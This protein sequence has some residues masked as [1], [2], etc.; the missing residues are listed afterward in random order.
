MVLVHIWV[1]LWN[2]IRREIMEF[3]WKKMSFCTFLFD[4]IESN[5]QGIYDANYKIY[6]LPDL[7]Q[8]VLK[9]PT[10]RGTTEVPRLWHEAV[11]RNVVGGRRRRNVSWNRSKVYGDG[12]VQARWLIRLLNYELEL[13]WL[14]RW[15]W[16]RSADVRVPIISSP[17]VECRLQVVSTLLIENRTAVQFATVL[18]HL[19]HRHQNHLF[20]FF[21]PNL[22]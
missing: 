9:P 13:T 16:R 2:R 22:V 11:R 12:K 5:G 6:S 4:V 14:K 17:H 19:N 15:Q 7:V 21:Q 18:L 8:S 10:F 1:K 20:G 3:C